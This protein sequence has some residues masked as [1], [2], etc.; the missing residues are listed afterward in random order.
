MNMKF[1]F[2]WKSV[3]QILNLMLVILSLSLTSFAFVFWAKMQSDHSIENT[4]VWEIGHRLCD[5]VNR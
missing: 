4:K 3:Y 2:S 1:K 5:L